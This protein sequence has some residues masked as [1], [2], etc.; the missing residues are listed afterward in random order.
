MPQG[1]APP[2]Q[3]GDVF[4]QIDDASTTVPSGAKRME[5]TP[6]PP[7]G[8]SWLTAR[9][10]PPATAASGKVAAPSG[11]ARYSSPVPGT[12]SPARAM[13]RLEKPGSNHTPFASAPASGSVDGAH[14]WVTAAA[15]A[16]TPAV[17]DHRSTVRPRHRRSRRA[18]HTCCIPR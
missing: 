6:P 9:Y 13:T 10:H 16:R 1:V 3:L 18:R 17:P 8:T 14:A 7:P 15:T 12:R 4:A 2:A 11:K 5:V